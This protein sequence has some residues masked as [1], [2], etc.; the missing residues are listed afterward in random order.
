MA[1]VVELEGLRIVV[2]KAPEWSALFCRR[3][4]WTGADGIYAVPFSGYEGP[5]RADQTRHLFVF[6]DTFVGEVGPDGARRDT[7]MV[8]NT[9][10]L[11]DG[12]APDPAR[13]RFL[14]GTGEEGKPAAVFLPRTP[15][16][17]RY[18]KCYYWLQDGVCLDGVVYILPMLIGPNPAGRKGFKFRGLGL[19][20]IA[21][22]LGADGP[23]L[24]R[25]TQV[26]TPF[27][28][29]NEERHL[30]FGAGL[31]PNTVDAG[32]PE[33]DG[34]VYV[35]GRYVSMRARGETQLAVARVPS[36][37][38]ADLGAWR[39]WDGQGWSPDIDDTAPL[40]RGGPELSVTPVTE[41]PL[42]GKYLMVSMH[43]E[44]ALYIRVGES[45]VG[46]FGPRIDIYTTSEPD[47]GQEI[48]TYNAKAH[49]SLSTPG[50]WLVSY[51]VNTTDW[52][53]HMRNGD[54]YR[55][56]FLKVRF[57]SK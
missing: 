23:E 41:G 44:R 52:D 14:W 18:E 12:G 19:C 47:A 55:P 17:E 54:I 3:E 20:L 31:M 37:A 34:Y 6:S 29:T 13:I 25:H 24:S 33:P 15:L 32:A 8:N 27:Y 43:V 11:L 38:F 49:P 56:R 45:P 48:Y 21:V 28:Y 10:A 53:S 39:F 9:L 51:N 57:E 5:G 50:E 42:A 2:E 36:D 7:V 35:Y 40:G 1:N 22:P 46:P 4:G 16:A 26:D 30:F